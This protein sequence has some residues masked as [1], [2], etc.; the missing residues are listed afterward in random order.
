MGL[1]IFRIQVKLIVIVG[2]KDALL[3]DDMEFQPEKINMP[4]NI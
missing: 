2:I 4:A 1:H 3:K